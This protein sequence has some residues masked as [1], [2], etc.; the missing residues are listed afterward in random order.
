[1]YLSSGVDW[2]MHG[3]TSAKLVYFTQYMLRHSR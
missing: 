1:M 2:Q 3:G